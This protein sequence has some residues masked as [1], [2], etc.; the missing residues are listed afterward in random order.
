[1][2][3]VRTVEI[4]GDRL[5]PQHCL[6]IIPSDI[7]DDELVKVL[8]PIQPWRPAD[9][10]EATQFEKKQNL[11]PHFDNRYWRLAENNQHPT[12][13]LFAWKNDPGPGM[14]IIGHGC[15]LDRVP[16][17]AEFKFK[18]KA[19]KLGL[20]DYW[21]NGGLVVLSERVLELLLEIDAK[22]IAYRQIEMRNLKNDLFDRDHYLV[23]ITR[24]VWAVDYANSIVEYHGPETH[25]GERLP[26]RAAII[27]SA[28]FRADLSNDFHIFRQR[29]SDQSDFSTGHCFISNVLKERLERLTP[30][31]RNL[32]F[33]PLYEGA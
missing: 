12:D 7:K 21:R 1:M 33:A 31:P 32:R 28:R 19:R 2:K 26:A 22:A 11:F 14:P 27:S 6:P 13:T 9:A 25:N 10:I 30:R 15:G 8:P 29:L 20:P 5:L 3:S 16:P 4:Q 18:P 23:D 17:V 24:V